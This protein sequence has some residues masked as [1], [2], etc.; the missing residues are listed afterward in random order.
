MHNVAAVV[1]GLQK[2]RDQAVLEARAG[3]PVARK[4]QLDGS[5][6]CKDYS[7]LLLEADDLRRMR[8]DLGSLSP[9]NGWGARQPRGAAPRGG[10]AGKSNR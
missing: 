2:D 6:W 4:Q 5:N 7:S 10:G 8:K 3:G 9:K 1:T